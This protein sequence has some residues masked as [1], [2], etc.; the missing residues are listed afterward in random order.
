MNCLTRRRF[1]EETLLAAAAGAFVEPVRAVA[2]ADKPSSSPNERLRVAVLGVRGRGQGHA[3]AY[4]ARSDC[5]LACVCD[6]DREIGEKYAARHNAKGRSVKFVQ[7]LRRVFDDKSVDIVSIATPNHWHSLA[8]IWAMQAGKD[9]YVEKPVS[10]NVSEG[11]R[12]VEVARKYGR[13]CQGGTQSRSIGS[14]RAAAQYVRS[15]KLGQ[16]QLVR[17]VMHRPRTP[18]GPAGHYA[19]PPSVD[20]NLWPVRPRW[21]PSR[22]SRS[23]TTGT[24][25]GTSATARSATTTCT[26]WI[27]R[28]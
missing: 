1:L 14:N 10:H 9:V 24:G 19:V 20:Y 4:A 18:I 25:S 5:Q 28:G 11:R 6:A 16:I 27:R 26:P 23:I 15:G 3:D 22:A 21:L 8:A 2:A 13:I 12:M 7:D 17:C